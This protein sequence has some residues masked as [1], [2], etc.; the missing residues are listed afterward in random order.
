MGGSA[1]YPL[2]M[3]H[4]QAADLKDIGQELAE[5]RTLSGLKEKSPG[6]FY[7]KSTSYLHFHDKD[8]KRWA[9]VKVD[10]SWKNVDLDFKAS[11]AQKTKFLKAARLA[12]AKI[13]GGK[14]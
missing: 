11:A 7:F 12:H 3:A 10:G 4:T 8:G 14:K 2:G 6:I 9:D 1:L 5:L 13:S